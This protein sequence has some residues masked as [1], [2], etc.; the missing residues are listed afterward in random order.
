[1]VFLSLLAVGLGASPV[2]AEFFAYVLAASSGDVLVIDTT[3]GSLTYHSTIA[4]AMVKGMAWQLPRSTLPVRISG[5][6]SGSATTS[7]TITPLFSNGIARRYVAVGSSL[8][9]RKLLEHF[10]RGATL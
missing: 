3:P 4:T 6:C 5:R 2:A 8:P 7:G 1:V 10:D 9:R